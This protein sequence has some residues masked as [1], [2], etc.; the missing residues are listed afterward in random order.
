MVSSE[1]SLIENI[2][3]DNS[4]RELPGKADFNCCVYPGKGNMLLG[5]PVTS[6]PARGLI[7]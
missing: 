6:W 2:S 7:D 1:K 5:N 4:N 3:I